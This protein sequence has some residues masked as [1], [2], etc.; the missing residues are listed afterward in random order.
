[1]LYANELITGFGM[2]AGYLES[3]EKGEK[4]WRICHW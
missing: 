4:L 1:M 2:G 3:E